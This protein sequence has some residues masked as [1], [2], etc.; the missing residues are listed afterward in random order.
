MKVGILQFGQVAPEVL[1][2]IQEGLTK[3]FPEMTCKLISVLLA[4]P[5]NALDKKRD[6]YSSSIPLNEVNAF[7]A[8]TKGSSEYYV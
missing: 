3:T 6:Q 4:V 1:V 2:V 5:Q 8:K 7:L